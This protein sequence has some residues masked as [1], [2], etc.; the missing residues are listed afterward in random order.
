MKTE[1]I[2]IDE[3][4][5]KILNEQDNNF[6]EG[7]FAAWYGED[8]SG[9]TYEGGLD[10]SNKNLT[11]LF[12]CPLTVTR[13]FDCSYNRLTSLEGVGEVKGEIYSDLDFI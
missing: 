4:V 13:Y 6:P 10:C 1:G 3:D 2:K 7:S 8:L 9:Q 11:S 12:G 5:V